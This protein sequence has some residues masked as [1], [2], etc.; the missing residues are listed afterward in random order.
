MSMLLDKKDKLIIRVS[1][2]GIYEIIKRG[3]ILIKSS[4]IWWKI[5]II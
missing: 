2:E 1:L 5:K 4:S 3:M